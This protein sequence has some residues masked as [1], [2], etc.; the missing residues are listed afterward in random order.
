[1]LCRAKFFGT[2]STKQEE[3]ARLGIFVR[4]EA[5]DDQTASTS[6]SFLWVISQDGKSCEKRIVS[7]GEVFEGKFIEVTKG[8]L[9]GE[10][11]IL[12]PPLNLRI[13][14]SVKVNKIL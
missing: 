13:G 10:Q 5:F 9:P 7:F 12:N 2:S 4:K 14:D 8:L 3:H 1:M 6:E 11:V